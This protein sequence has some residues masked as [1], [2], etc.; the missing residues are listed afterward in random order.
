VITE[1]ALSVLTLTMKRGH[2]A[3]PLGPEQLW[4]CIIGGCDSNNNNKSKAN[5]TV[6]RRE[7]GLV[8]EFAK[9]LR[10]LNDNKDLST[11]CLICKVCMRKASRLR[12]SSR[13]GDNALPIASISTSDNVDGIASNSNVDETMPPIT[14]VEET[15]VRSAAANDY[16]ATAS[17]APIDDDAGDDLDL[18]ECAGI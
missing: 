18:V 7:I 16:G 4:G 1:S 10:I 11:S 5:R 12:D 9:W 8:T 3:N 13:P 2:A 15:R 6:K 17:Q 14:V